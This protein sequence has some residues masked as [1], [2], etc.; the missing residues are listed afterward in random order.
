MHY[1]RNTLFYYDSDKD[2]IRYYYDHDGEYSDHIKIHG[3]ITVWYP[4]N[5]NNNKI[6]KVKNGDFLLINNKDLPSGTRSVDLLKFFNSDFHFWKTRLHEF[7]KDN[8]P[9]YFI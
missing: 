1:N 2:M 4:S 3:K 8:Y 9:E 5:S 7:N 6:L